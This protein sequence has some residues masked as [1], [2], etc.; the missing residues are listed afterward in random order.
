VGAFA[1]LSRRRFVFSASHDAD[2]LR[3]RDVLRGLGSG[4]EVRRARL[5]YRLGLRCAHAVVAQ[6]EQQ[7]ALGRT[8]FGLDPHVIRSFCAPA[9][10]ATGDAAAFLWVG[11]FIEA[12]DPLSYVALASALPDV[13][14]WMV[15]TDRAIAGRSLAAEV[16]R[17]ADRLP[18]LELLA[19]RPRGELIA[20]YDRAFALVSTSR[21]EGFPNVFL[22][23]WARGVPVIS[24]R[25]DPDGMIAR[26]GLGVVADGSSEAL[27]NAVRTYHDDPSLARE[28][29]A[30]ARGYVTE[31]HAPEIVGPR[32]LMLVE[33]LLAGAS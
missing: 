24:L 7:A 31:H 21:L 22:E 14:F 9:P 32:W 5:Q 4:D 30:S 12:K 6:T 19:P 25:V 11:A 33:R 17:R 1:R 2:F 28:A 16:R 8:N 3:E 29:G 23:A 15:A 10:A 26:A 27:V 13:P 18:N 20:L